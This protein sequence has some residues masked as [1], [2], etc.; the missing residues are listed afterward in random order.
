MA[1]KKVCK[2]H[3]KYAGDGG[4]SVEIENYRVT[5]SKTIQER[6]WWKKGRSI[7][8]ELLEEAKVIFIETLINFEERDL[9]SFFT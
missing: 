2:K 7:V 5:I 1:I 8:T 3:A 9:I 6:A 4:S